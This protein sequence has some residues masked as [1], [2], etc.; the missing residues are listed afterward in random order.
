MGLPSSLDNIIYMM[1]PLDWTTHGPFIPS[2][3][4]VG[5]G[6]KPSQLQC[7]PCSIIWLL[8]AATHPALPAFLPSSFDYLIIIPDHYFAHPSNYRISHVSHHARFFS[9]KFR[10]SFF[11]YSFSFNFHENSHFRVILI[12]IPSNIA[13]TQTQ[14]TIFFPQIPSKL[15]KLN[16]TRCLIV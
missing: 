6:F 4:G 2:W 3:Y 10:G 12:F 15:L 8:D 16:N 9:L 1:K 7:N 11:F 14:R 13:I 5:N